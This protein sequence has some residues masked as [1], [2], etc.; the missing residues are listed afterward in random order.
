ML[1]GTYY[2]S[3]PRGDYRPPR[4]SLSRGRRPVSVKKKP[5]PP[6]FHNAWAGLDQVE[7]DQVEGDQD[8]SAAA[9]QGLKSAMY[10]HVIA[11]EEG[12]RR[13]QRHAEDP[14][15][16]V[17]TLSLVDSPEPFEYKQLSRSRLRMF[18]RK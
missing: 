13:G 18:T 6:V 7:G 1:S 3:W 11:H 14:L 10:G 15:L 9:P 16:H 17:S 2:D 8:L 12:V 4:R 5:E